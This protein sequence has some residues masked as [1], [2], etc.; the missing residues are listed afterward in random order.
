MDIKYTII[1]VLI[2]LKILEVNIFHQGFE[3]K[4]YFLYIVV[5]EMLINIF[6]YNEQ[7]FSMTLFIRSSTYRAGLNKIIA[8]CREI[9]NQIITPCRAVL[10]Q[11]ITPYRAALKPSV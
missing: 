3:D 1:I 10:N 6:L 5:L 7:I 9:L 8:S 4:I 2:V 11:I